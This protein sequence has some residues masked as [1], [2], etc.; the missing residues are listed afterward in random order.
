MAD[1]S[2]KKPKRKVGVEIQGESYALDEIPSHDSAIV[3]AATERL[4]GAIDLKTLVN[5][6]GKVG[7]FI[8]IAYNGVG[9]VGYGYTKEQIEI[10]RLGY[11]ITKLCD[12]SALTVAKFKQASRS[13]LTRLQCAYGYLLDNLEE[14]A[15]ETVSSIS[16]I[17]G[18]MEKAALELHDKFVEEGDKVVAA[19][20]NTQNAKKLQA[21]KVKEEEEK[22]MKLENDIKREKTLMMEYLEKE[23]EAEVRRQELER[24]ED[25]AISEIGSLN[26]RDTLKSLANAFTSRIGVGKLFDPSDA[27]TRAAKWRESRLDILEVEKSIREKR[28]EALARMKTFVVKL[29][30]CKNETEMAGCAVDAL[31]EAAGTLKHLSVVMMQAANFWKQVQDYCHSLAENEMKSLVKTAMEISEEKRLQIWTSPSFKVQAI[32]FYSDW[33]AL[34]KVCGV[35]MEQI[36]ETQRNLYKYMTENPTYEESKDVLKYL[37]DQFK[38]ELNH[39]QNALEEEGLKAQKEMLSL[40]PS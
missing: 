11:G 3:K 24:Q 23:K 9:A 31:H 28:L 20:E 12:K 1:L 34:N 15:L 33:V 19:L 26:V 14:M 10:Q 39:D 36:K 8:R 25:Q 22:R 16:N 35:Y 30:Q 13:V 7:R 40:N 27:S 5:D 21:S 2:P 38:V 6:L 17:A 29:E 4:L 18:N 32:N 37:T